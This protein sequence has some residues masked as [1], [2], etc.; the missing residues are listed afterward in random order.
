MAAHSRKN[1]VSQNVNFSRTN[2]YFCIQNVFHCISEAVTQGGE[3][4]RYKDAEE[5][6]GKRGQMKDH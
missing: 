3:K 6:V 2:K 4:R 5:G 1:P